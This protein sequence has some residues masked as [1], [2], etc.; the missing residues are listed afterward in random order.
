MT[1]LKNRKIIAGTVA[2]FLSVIILMPFLMHAADKGLVPCDGSAQDPCNF[3]QMIVMINGIIKWIISI[4]MVIF[5][6]SAIYGGF[7]YMTSGDKPGNKDKAKTILWST[8][9]GFVIILVAWLIV[10][11]L[12]KTVVR[13]GTGNSIFNF[14]GKF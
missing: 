13:N 8:L 4:A 14:I 11:T 5:T 12:L 10:F 1:Y 2:S 3:D 9:T 6:I 7:L